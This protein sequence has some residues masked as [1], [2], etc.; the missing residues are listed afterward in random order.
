[1]SFIYPRKVSIVRPVS[2]RGLGKV[3]YNGQRPGNQQHEQSVAEKLPA[4]IQLMKGMG[5]PA[6]GLPGDA[7][8]KT[9]WRILIPLSAIANG[10][11]KTH[12]VVI[13][14]LGERYDVT[15]A[16]WNSLGYGL[17]TEKLDV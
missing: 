14:D 1:M 5:R 6:S 11:I 9:I 17:L 7:A 13:D 12:D 8:Q 2:G 4:S 3:G 15:A 16:Y 10:A